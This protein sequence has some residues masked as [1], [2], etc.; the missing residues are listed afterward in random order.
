[1]DPFLIRESKLN[2]ENS[3]FS[4][5]M[6]KMISHT[7]QLGAVYMR[8]GTRHQTTKSD[9]CSHFFIYLLHLHE[10][11]TYFISFRSG[12]IQLVQG[13]IR[14]SRDNIFHINTSSWDEKGPAFLNFSLKD[15][16]VCFTFLRSSQL[17]LQEKISQSLR[18]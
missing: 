18:T 9:N 16:L 5:M 17:E 13:E 7:Q 2:I 6:G 11:G 15:V 8:A 12:G 3:I 14:H 10:T 4:F 1:M